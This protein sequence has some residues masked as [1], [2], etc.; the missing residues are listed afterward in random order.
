MTPAE[1]C[2]RRIGGRVSSLS[3]SLMFLPAGMRAAFI[4]L[5]AFAQ[6]VADVPLQCHEPAV[7]LNKLHWW[8]EEIHNAF[9]AHAIHPVTQALRPLLET[10]KVAEN[11]FQDLI[12]AHV[13][14]IAP[15]RYPTFKALLEHGQQVGGGIQLMARESPAFQALA[16]FEADRILAMQREVQ[17]ALPP[18]RYTTLLPSLIL[19]GLDRALLTEIR[20]DGYHILNRQIALTPLRRLWI[21]WRTRRRNRGSARRARP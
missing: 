1:Y 3:C 9:G 13:A 2:L 7:A 6:E 19:A 14:D 17:A 21:A 16:A 20:A 15:V 5:H 11:A 8:R 12:S 10:A 4:A 18:A